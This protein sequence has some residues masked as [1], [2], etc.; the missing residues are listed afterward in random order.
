MIKRGCFITLEGGEGVGKTTNL[1]FIKHWLEAQGKTVI[2]TR[3]PGGTPLAEQIRKLLLDP[4]E[5]VATETELLLMFASR[6]QHLAE[7][8][9]PALMRGDW[10]LCSRFTDSTYAYQGGGRNIAAN[11]IDVLANWLHADC[12][13]DATLLLDLPAAVG[14]ARARARDQLD[15]IEQEQIDFFE[16]VR[17]VYLQRAKSSSVTAI[18]DASQSLSQ[19]QEQL[20]EA[21]SQQL[22]IVL[23]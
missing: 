23:H 17:Q 13:P 1:I 8:I 16:R 14:L 10:L 12:Q 7:V 18:I 9:R 15:R 21:L 6:A 4:D 3:E 5:Q 11:R 19:V 2:L 22:G 20:V